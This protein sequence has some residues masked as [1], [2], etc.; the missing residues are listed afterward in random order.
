ML[1]IFSVYVQGFGLPRKIKDNAVEYR[2][3]VW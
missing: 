2:A 1:G 3:Q